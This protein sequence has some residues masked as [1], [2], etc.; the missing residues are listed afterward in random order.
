MSE[1]PWEYGQTHRYVACGNHEAAMSR[2]D[3]WDAFDRATDCSDCVT[4]VRP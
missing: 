3:F 4:E 2:M 1:H